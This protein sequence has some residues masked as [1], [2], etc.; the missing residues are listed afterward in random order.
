MSVKNFNLVAA[1]AVA[2]GLTVAANATPVAE[3]LLNDLN[4]TTFGAS[5]VDKSG[6]VVVIV[7]ITDAN[8]ETMRP[9][10]D[11]RGD[12]RIFAGADAAVALAK[13]SNLAADT[14]I[15]IVRMEKPANVGDPVATLKIKHKGFKAESLEADKSVTLLT[16]KVSAATSLGWNTAVGTP[17]A[18]E[19]A[20]LV[21]RQASIAEW[22]AF[23]AARV[24]ARA[25]AL[26]AA[27]VNPDTYAPI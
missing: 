17:E 14:A 16:A 11:V 9:V 20:D 25:A 23:V 10:C 18:D 22:K 2:L 21:K 6:R 5:E 26:T 15:M 19:F 4:V 27:G 3:T 12:V 1:A 13:R 8:V 24:I 7:G